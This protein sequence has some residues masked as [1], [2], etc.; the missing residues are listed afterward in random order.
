MLM[1]AAEADVTATIFVGEP[2][3]PFVESVVTVC[4]TPEVN[5]SPFARPALLTFRVE[6]ILAPDTVTLSPEKVTVLNVFPPPANVLLVAD[7]SV[8]E[9]VDVFALKVRFVAVEKFQTVPVPV[10]EKLDAPSVSVLVLLEL[11]L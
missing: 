11:P 6:N 8:T 5:L 3:E 7:V 2:V 1:V 9:M 10:T 4:V